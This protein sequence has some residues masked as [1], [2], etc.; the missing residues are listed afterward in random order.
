MTTYTVTDLSSWNTAADATL[1]SSDTVDI[2]SDITYSASFN[3]IELNGASVTGNN[4]TITI[5][6]K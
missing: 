5:T 4:N 2:T 3:T 1:T 6:A